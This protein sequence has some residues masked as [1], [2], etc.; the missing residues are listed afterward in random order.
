[1]KAE[2]LSQLNIGEKGKIKKITCNKHLQRRLIDLG[3]IDGTTVECV[4]ISPYGSPIAF[5]IR[6]AVIALR[7]DN[8]DEIR[9]VRQI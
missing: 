7:R 1:M 6:G 2:N 4:H 5:N 9:I 8:C 3:L